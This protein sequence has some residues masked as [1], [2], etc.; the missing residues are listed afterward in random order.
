MLQYFPFYPSCITLWTSCFKLYYKMYYICLKCII[1]M[2]LLFLNVLS[3]CLSVP[4][5]LETLFFNRSVHLI[6]SILSQL[7]SQKQLTCIYVSIPPNTVLQIYVFI[8]LFFWYSRNV[9]SSKN[10]IF[11][12]SMKVSCY[13][14]NCKKPIA[15]RNN[16]F[17]K[18]HNSYNASYLKTVRPW[19]K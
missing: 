11:L 18:K 10:S 16:G 2:S 6:F 12:F 8:A 13:H 9:L 7:K 1:K 17:M 15:G 14:C 19:N 4:T 5:L 3:E